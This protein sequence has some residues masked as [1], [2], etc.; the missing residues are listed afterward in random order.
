LSLQFSGYDPMDESFHNYLKRSKDVLIDAGLQATMNPAEMNVFVT[1]LEDSN[2]L[3]ITMIVVVPISAG[4]VVALVVFIKR[5][6]KLNK[7]N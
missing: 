4:I 6:K 1:S 2:P 7:K 5:R 3:V